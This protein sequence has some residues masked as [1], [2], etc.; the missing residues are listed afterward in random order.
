MNIAGHFFDAAFRKLLALVRFRLLWEVRDLWEEEVMEI[1]P[2]RAATIKEATIRVIKEVTIKEATIKEGMVK[3]EIKVT[4][5][6]VVTVVIKEDI[7]KVDTV[8]K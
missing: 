2:T 6:K 7:I 5:D 8:S 4:M 3:V 1:T